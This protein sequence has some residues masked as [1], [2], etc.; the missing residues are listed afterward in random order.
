MPARFCHPGSSRVG[1]STEVEPPTPWLQ[2]FL[3]RR[4]LAAGREKRAGAIASEV[5]P[6][7]QFRPGARE[8]GPMTH[9]LIRRLFLA[10]VVGVLGK[11]PTTLNW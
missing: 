1:R 2:L 4:R 7:G 8:R 3:T 9:V 6:P 10:R 5:L 11:A